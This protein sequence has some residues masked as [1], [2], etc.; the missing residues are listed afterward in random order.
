MRRPP[1]EGARQGPSGKPGEQCTSA[2]A[3][4]VPLWIWV[5]GLEV[6][7]PMNTVRSL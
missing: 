1:N 2:R 3:R 7:A 5:N 4:T 6:E